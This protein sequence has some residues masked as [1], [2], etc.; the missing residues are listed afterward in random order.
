MTARW[1]NATW[2]AEYAYQFNADRFFDSPNLLPAVDQRV[3]N[4]SLSRNFS[5]WRLDMELNNL[6]NQN[7][8]DFNGYPKPGRAGFVSITYLPKPEA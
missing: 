5:D 1:S 6:T 4:V 8:E 7:Y 2:K 3:H